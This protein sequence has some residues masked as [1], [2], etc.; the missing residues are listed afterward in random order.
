MMMMM[1]M[2]IIIIIMMMMVMSKMF[3]YIMH[4]RDIT[5]AYIKQLFLE[6][7]T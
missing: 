7:Q 3:M 5:E 4:V 2:M 1:M 6:A